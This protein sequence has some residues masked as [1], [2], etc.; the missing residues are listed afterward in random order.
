MAHNANLPAIKERLWNGAVEARLLFHT[1]GSS[2]PRE[3]VLSLHRNLYWPL[4][5]GVI[6]AYFSRHVPE[7]AAKPLWLAYKGT[8]I[9]WNLPVG[10]LYD[11]TFH[12]T[13]TIWPLTVHFDDYPA[14]SIIPFIYSANGLIDYHRSLKEVVV[15]QLKQSCFVLHGNS[16]PIMNLG[17]DESND[18]WD[19]IVQH[20]LSTFTAINAKI[21]PKT[22]HRI[23]VKIYYK[24]S[25]IQAPILPQEAGSPTLLKDTLARLIPGFD[26]RALAHVHGIDVDSLLTQRESLLAEIWSIFRHL[27]NFLYVIVRENESSY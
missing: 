14:E 21:T 18:F 22:P 19:A 3:L 7:N 27:D 11:L 17:K 8:P 9:K 4:Q 24:D 5:Y 16:K 26:E 2:S 20:N 1:E 6:A 23:P 13:D 10:V 25:V 12:G 15:N